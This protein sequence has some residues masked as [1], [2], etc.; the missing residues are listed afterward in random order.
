M[1]NQEDRESERLLRI[2]PKLKRNKQ[3]KTETN[4]KAD[5]RKINPVPG[6]RKRFDDETRR[7]P[8]ERRCSTWSLARRTGSSPHNTEGCR[9]ARESVTHD[10]PSLSTGGEPEG[11]RGSETRNTRGTMAE[12]DLP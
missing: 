9:V 8:G 6:Q 1:E 3:T 12:I 5:K 4:P 2:W 7:G 10:E 11:G